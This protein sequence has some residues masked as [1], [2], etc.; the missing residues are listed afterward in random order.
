MLDIVHGEKWDAFGDGARALLD[1]F[2][3]IRRDPDL[4]RSNEGVTIVVL[5]RRGG[6]APGGAAAPAGRKR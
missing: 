4:G 1:R 3:E 2:P 5:A 6:A